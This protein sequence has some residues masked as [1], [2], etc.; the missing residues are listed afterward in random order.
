MQQIGSITSAEDK[1]IA[2]DSFTYHESN[3][4]GEFFFT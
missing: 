1:A 3:V 2:M 4:R